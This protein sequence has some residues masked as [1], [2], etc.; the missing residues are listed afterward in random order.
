MSFIDLNFSY[1]VDQA[2]ISGF[3]I[4]T[5]LGQRLNC[6]LQSSLS[7]SGISL[8]FGF[9]AFQLFLVFL[10]RVTRSFALSRQFLD[11]RHVFGFKSI[12]FLLPV[13]RLPAKA[14]QDSCLTLVKSKLLVFTFII[15]HDC[16]GL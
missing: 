15:G 14:L 6:L 10:E 12:K 3:Q 2:L 4:S 8:E 11:L 16:E 13:F 7:F 5:L 1:F 9:E